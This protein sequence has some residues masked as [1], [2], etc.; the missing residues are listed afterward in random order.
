V[1]RLVRLAAAFSILFAFTAQ[2]AT[3]S[4][5]PDVQPLLLSVSEMPLGWASYPLGSPVAQGC[6]SPVQDLLARHPG[7]WGGTNYQ[8]FDGSA[9]ATEALFSWPSLGAAQQAWASTNA[10]LSACHEFVP[11]AGGETQIE[12]L[13]LGRLGDASAA[14]FATNELGWGFAV[15]LARTGPV[16]AALV[17]SV[18]VVAFKPGTVLPFF[19]SA[20]AKVA[21]ALAPRAVQPL[22][23]TAHAT[24]AVVGPHGGRVTLEA[25]LRGAASCQL[26]LLSRQGF[27]VTY[28]SNMR[29]CRTTFVAH[30]TIAAN[31]TRIE[32]HVAFA[33]VAR[34]GAKS[35]TGRLWVGLEHKLISK[36]NRKHR[37]PR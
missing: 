36:S 20:L 21:V 37:T 12:L 4:A 27:A 35:F 31:P 16:V 32:R 11:A 18:P 25:R 13:N 7:S 5:V 17:Y 22:I 9:F 28:A 30:I 14:W 15:V 3:A 19:Q 8:D 24:P 33:L 29:P 6:W 26:E 34:N 1:T 2:P 10:L 23:L